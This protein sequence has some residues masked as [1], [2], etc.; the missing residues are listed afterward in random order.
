MN[1][2]FL[3]QLAAIL[4]AM[5]LLT[6]CGKNASPSSDATMRVINFG[7]DYG[8]INVAFDDSGTA[9][10]FVSNLTRESVSGYA[11]IKSGTRNFTVSSVSGGGSLLVQSL[12]PGAAAKYTLITYGVSS[13]PR[14][15]LMEDDNFTQPVMLSQGALLRPWALL[16]NPVGVNTQGLMLSQS[17]VL[18]LWAV[19]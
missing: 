16:Y 18:R 11:N 13:S 19:E 12:T 1:K 7:V 2:R 6:S 10:G 17:S 15:L 5:V 8:A 3:L 4:S 9:T 14:A